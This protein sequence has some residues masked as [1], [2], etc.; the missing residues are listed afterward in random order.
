MSYRL[1][2]S[3]TWFMIVVAF[4]LSSCGSQHVEFS[5]VDGSR[6]VNE[7]EEGEDSPG[8]SAIHVRYFR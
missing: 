5:E 3:S 6:G 4:G 8:G 7:F 1:S 2:F